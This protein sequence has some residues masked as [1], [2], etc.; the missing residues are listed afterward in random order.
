MRH[1]FLDGVSVQGS[2][3]KREQHV[4][5]E[6]AHG[7]SG[8]TLRVDTTARQMDAWHICHESI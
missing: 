3:G 1:R 4:V 8:C 5:F 6:E 2:P 7:G